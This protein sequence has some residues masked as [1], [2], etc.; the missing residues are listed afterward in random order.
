MPAAKGARAR[1]RLSWVEALTAGMR[2]LRCLRAACLRG[3]RQLT[4]MTSRRGICARCAR[5]WKIP[6]YQIYL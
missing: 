5:G 2:R 1:A 4:A 3:Y 6:K